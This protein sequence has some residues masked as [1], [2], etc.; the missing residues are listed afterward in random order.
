MNKNISQYIN[1][2]LRFITVVYS[3]IVLAAC[4]SSPVDDAGIAQADAV[5]ADP[6]PDVVKDPAPVE[7]DNLWDRVGSELTWQDIDNSRIDKQRKALLRQPYYLQVISERAHYYLFHIVE[8]VEARDMP[9]ELA[10]LPVV[11]ST[12]DP[13]AFSYSGAAGLWQIMPRTGRH[14]GLERNS[15][16]D[17]RQ[18]LRDSTDGALDYLQFLNDRFD[19]DWL[20][21]VA[22]YNAGE[23]TIDRARKSNASRGKATDY[24][25]LSLRRQAR[26]YVPKLIALTQIVAAPDTY[27]LEVPFVANAPAFEVTEPDAPL[28]L[29]RAA[30][31]AGVDID[32]VRALNPGLRRGTLSPH[33]PRELLLP[34]GTGE[35]FTANLAEHGPGQPPAAQ[36]YRI[37]SGDTLSQIARRFGTDVAHLRAANNLHGSRIR[38]GDTLLIPGDAALVSGGD[39]TATGYF[40]RAGDSLYRIANR[41]KVSVSNIV[42]WNG[43]DPDDYLQPGQK[44]TLYIGD[45]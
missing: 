35:E 14:L 28:H 10:L 26:E 43:L 22:A 32:T 21:A 9:M 37:R 18:A 20:L 30:Q 15:W 8:E 44:L 19:G 12:L 33:G 6:P 17:G 45:G 29:S 3:A 36:T 40:V 11:E 25:S 41:F 27:G 34:V 38:A 7:H 42:V 24:W 23:G 1:R 2:L 16:Y 5:R 39:A 31:L 4:T 13:F